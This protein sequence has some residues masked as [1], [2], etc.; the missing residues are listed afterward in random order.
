MREDAGSPER[1]GLPAATW[2]LYDFGYSLFAY[3][4]FARD[5]S[6]WLISDLGHPDWIYTSGQAVAALS[7]L[8]LMPLA[9]VAADV[10]GRHRPLLAL[11]TIITV[12][13]AGLVGD[14]SCFSNFLNM[15]DSAMFGQT[16]VRVLKRQP[17]GVFTYSSS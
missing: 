7:L 8:L 9:G 5:L 17:S 4:V 11:F 13:A 15:T 14:V 2:A 10:L 6:D 12:T 16:C 1:I 3:V